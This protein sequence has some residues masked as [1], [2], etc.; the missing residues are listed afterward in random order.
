[1][2]SNE[3]T[4]V[5]GRDRTPQKPDRRVGAPAQA[6]VGGALRTIYEEAMNEQVPQEMLDLL[7]K[8]D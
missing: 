6:G 8:L 2:P 7:G 4:R 3:D 5:S 1:M